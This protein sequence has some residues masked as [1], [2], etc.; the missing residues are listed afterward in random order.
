MEVV[1]HNG[2]ECKFMCNKEAKVLLYKLT[3]P[4][5]K[6]YIGQTVQRLKDRIK[7][8]CNEA[9]NM[10]DRRNTNPKNRAIRKYR[11]FTVEIVEY[12][13]NVDELNMREDEVINEY[14]NNGYTLYNVA[15]GGLNNCNYFG[16][17]CVVT[18]YNFNIIKEFDK[19]KYACEYVGVSGN[20]TSNISK[21]I[22][23]KGRYY[24][25]NL[26]DYKKYTPKDFIENRERINE[27]IKKRIANSHQKNKGLNKV[28]YN[29]VQIDYKYNV[30][31]ILDIHIAIDKYGNA[32]HNHSR[33]NAN[34]RYVYGYYWI[35]EI[36]YKRLINNSIPIDSVL[37]GLN[38]VLQV[39]GKGS[40][41]GEYLT[42]REASKQTG[43]SVPSI[44]NCLNS[45]NVCSDKFYFEWSSRYDKANSHS[46][47]TIIEQT[48]TP[49][50]IYEYD[51]NLQLINM[52][53]SIRSCAICKGLNKETVKRM[54]S[55]KSNK[56][57]T[58]L[59][60][61]PLSA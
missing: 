50:E 54:I 36:E 20:Y 58:I 40:V 13:N 28:H 30:I 6:I 26:N 21:Y 51:K 44:G 8:H 37:S 35:K 60:F 3:F 11:T 38:Y 47:R 59:S 33:N 1:T 29:V 25:L 55:K 9:V 41:I 12:C 4:N 10:H 22:L 32:I 27:E 2:I 5:N 18:D 53:S 49:K 43:I 16:N 23:I 19:I 56:Y 45:N 17:K 31:D 7:T 39:D 14:R 61:I 48:S 24:I 46:K 15:N 52:Y 34:I 42:I 57:E